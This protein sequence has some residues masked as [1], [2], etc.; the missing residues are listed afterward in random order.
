MCIA[1]NR[2]IFDMLSRFATAHDTGS[3]WIV[4]KGD[5]HCLYAPPDQGASSNCG[6]LALKYTLDCGLTLLVGTKGYGP[7]GK[8]ERADLLE[9]IDALERHAQ[10]NR[11]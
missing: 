8:Q 4:D 5:T 6:A 9:I 1:V 3:I 10:E 11:I 2:R 7:P